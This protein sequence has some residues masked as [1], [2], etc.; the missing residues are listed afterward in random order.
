MSLFAG[1]YAVQ[2]GGRPV[3]P[4]A[5][6]VATIVRNI[7]RAGDPVQEFSSDRFFLAKVDVGAFPA[8]AYHHLPGV[9]VAALAGQMLIDGP[10]G[11]ADR[12]GELVAMSSRLDEANNDGLRRCRGS[13]ALCHYTVASHRLLLATDK[14]GVRP[15]Y[16]SAGPDHLYF[17]NSLRVL[18]AI[19]GVPK[20]LDMQ[21]LAE[22][23]AFKYP[24]GN[25]TP[26]ADVKILEAAEMLSC[27]DGAIAKEFYFRSDTLDPLSMTEDR[28]LD[29]AY[30]LFREAV[31]RRCDPQ[32]MVVSLL[33]GGLDSRCIVMMLKQLGADFTALTFE[34]G[35]IDDSLARGL[36]E[37]IGV[38]HRVVPGFGLGE[39]GWSSRIRNVRWEGE[40]QPPATPL[41]FSGDGGSVGVGYVYVEENDI[42]ALREKGVDSLAE[43]FW[44]AAR[45]SERFYDPGVYRKLSDAL[46]DGIREE[47]RRIECADAGRAVHLFYMNNDQRR[48]LHPLF[49]NVD[50]W[51][52]EFL[53]PFFDGSFMD[54]ILS[55]PVDLFPRHRFY[56]RWAER[57]PK[58]FMAVPWQTYHGHL[59]CP[60]KGDITGQTQWDRTRTTRWV[61]SL[62]SV[63]RTIAQGITAGFPSS[64][65]RRGAVLLAAALHASF[66]R[67]Y[68]HVF[69]DL[70]VVGRY[71][72][73]CS[74]VHVYPRGRQGRRASAP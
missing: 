50:E 66:L 52:V 17:A 53:T 68:G 14:L 10:P 29:A 44:Q 3:P 39:M 57:F 9:H 2:S 38:R 61:R 56:H 43:K 34:H 63:R 42:R 6:S 70:Q 62:P 33:S 60:V 4:P 45:P 13:F 1:I 41:V 12:Q 71:E 58:G 54:L 31:A 18:E 72:R 22:I 24:L 16:Y 20:R 36:A 8:P 7:S 48:H 15:V 27:Q 37:A 51:R 5:D 21:G 69:A 35:C 23:V 67:D 26:Y 49:E 74:G 32:R 19:A 73:M 28:L 40:K 25:R 30:D 11:A 55:A 47:F 64:I 59:P 46:H 65:M